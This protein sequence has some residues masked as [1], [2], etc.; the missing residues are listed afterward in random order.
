LVEFGFWVDFG[1]EWKG[2]YSLPLDDFIT[3]DLLNS[4]YSPVP[5]LQNYSIE[6]LRR[7]L[8]SPLPKLLSIANAWAY[9]TL[10]EAS[11]ET[12]SLFQIGQRNTELYQRP[13]YRMLLEGLPV[14]A[15]GNEDV[16]HRWWDDF[17]NVPISELTG[18]EISRNTSK[19]TQTLRCRPDATFVYQQ[20]GIFRGEEKSLATEGD[21]VKELEDKLQWKLLEILPFVLGYS[22]IGSQITFH[23]FIIQNRTR[24][25]LAKFDLFRLDHRLKHFRF[26]IQV[27]RLLVLL[28]TFLTSEPVRGEF[29]PDIVRKNGQGDVISRIAFY[30]YENAVK[31]TLYGM[32]VTFFVDES[33]SNADLL[34]PLAP[35]MEKF[36]EVCRIYQ[37]IQTKKPKNVVFVKKVA[38]VHERVEITLA[39]IGTQVDPEKLKPN[40]LIDAIRC[41]LLGLI[42][43]HSFGIVHRDIRWEN[44][45]KNEDETELGTFFLVDFDDAS[46]G[47]SETPRIDFDR[48]T[49]APE[50]TR[51]PHSFSADIWSVGNLCK[52]FRGSL[53]REFGHLACQKIPSDR[54]TAQQLLE[55]LES[56]CKSS[57]KSDHKN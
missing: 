24:H 18:L 31:K 4:S 16:W 36:D 22:A 27:S 8:E 6:M 2:F 55:F 53:W 37:L 44:I 50:V 7:F 25:S 5:K 12:S 49:H 28:K 9:S 48:K 35:L 15:N 42:D 40:E 57:E 30:T 45:L 3:P 41:I 17:I 46:V 14:N 47:P 38:L 13:I 23:A 52:S 32:F 20:L 56:N 54:P 34:L 1:F 29:I 21:P 26:V 19:S 51:E 43:L 39:P 11:G 10:M 33:K